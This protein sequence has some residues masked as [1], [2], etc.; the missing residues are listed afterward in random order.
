MLAGFSAV[1]LDVARIRDEAQLPEEVAL[2][3]PDRYVSS[4]RLYRMWQAAHRLWGKPGLGLRTGAKVPFGAYEVLDYLATTGQT[5]GEALAQVARY[6]VIVTNTAGFKVHAEREQVAF[7]FVWRIPPEGVMFQLRDYS[8]AIIAARVREV[9]GSHV[10]PVRVELAGPSLAPEGDYQRLF[11]AP[12]FARAERSAL[13]FSRQA[14]ES[15][16]RRPDASLHQTL[17]RHAELLLERVASLERERW[18][19]RV[20]CEVL[21]QMKVGPPTIEAVARGLAIGARTLQRQ[22]QRE[23]VVY[24]ALVDEVRAMLAREYLKDRGITVGEVAYLLG[25]SETSAFSRAFRR[26]TGETPRE[27]RA[28]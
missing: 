13:F 9:I 17:R 7:E 5:V 4:S 21:R 19:D 14:W 27:F 6:V 12:T 24:S 3:D 16:S 8:V 10:T 11:G 15:R 25:F 2:A 28:G 22:L 26:W 18:I 20:R 1:G 23:G